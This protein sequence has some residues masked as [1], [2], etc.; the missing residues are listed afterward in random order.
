[1]KKME[2]SEK[3]FYWKYKNEGI[4]LIALIITVILLLIIAGAAISIAINGGDIFNKTSQARG[5][6]N[7]AVAKEQ[8]QIDELLQQ[9][10]LIGHENVGNTDFWEERKRTATKHPEQRNTNDIGIDAMGNIVNLDL[11]DYVFF[12]KASIINEVFENIREY[13]TMV[14]LG[15]GGFGCGDG[16]VGYAPYQEGFDGTG[17]SYEEHNIICPQFIKREGDS[18]FTPVTDF[19]A[20]MLLQLQITKIYCDTI[21]SN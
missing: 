3:R 15:L 5:G 10:D 9:I 21:N 6:W 12:N 1:M 8:E 19:G 7:E 11:W 13:E 18:D 20:R 14:M 17:L 2:Y 16:I 4:T